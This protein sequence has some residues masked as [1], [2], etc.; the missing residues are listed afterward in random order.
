MKLIPADR[1]G[2]TYIQY[3]YDDLV[4]TDLKA[5]QDRLVAGLHSGILTLNE[6]RA[7]MHLPSVTEEGV[8]D[9]RFFPA[10]LLPLNKDVLDSMMAR[11]KLALKELESQTE[12]KLNNHQDGGA[13]DKT[14]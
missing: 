10:N 2:A 7:A 12:D 1:R 9:A 13:A 11:S 14:M 5:K 6:V 8:G 3:S 4:E